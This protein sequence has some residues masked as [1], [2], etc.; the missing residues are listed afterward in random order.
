MLPPDEQKFL[1]FTLGDENFAIPLS[2][3]MKVMAVPP[4]TPIPN[5]PSYFRGLHQFKNQVIP[6]LDLRT[7]L[8][9]RPTTVLLAIPCVII[10]QLNNTPVGFVVDDINEVINFKESHIERQLDLCAQ[11]NHEFF[12][13]VIKSQ[14]T[15]LTLI[16]NLEMIYNSNNISRSDHQK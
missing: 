10:C 14:T 13:G 4:L 11:S 15:P 5:M 8:G 16:L 12:A 7:K 2:K 6:I 3:V 1:L 9:T